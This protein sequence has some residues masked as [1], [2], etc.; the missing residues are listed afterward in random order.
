MNHQKH[1]RI[2]F[3]GYDSWQYFF[4]L[5]LG[6]SKILLVIIFSHLTGETSSF[7]NKDGNVPLRHYVYKNLNCF[8]K[9]VFLASAF[10][11]YLLANT[12]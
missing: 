2:Y 7:H 10:T 5:G 6:R 11:P 8:C 1:D 9:Y 3:V 4:V 12:Q